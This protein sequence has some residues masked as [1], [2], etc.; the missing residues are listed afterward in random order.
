MVGFISIYLTLH[1]CVLL[2]FKGISS[3][4]GLF[5]IWC[6]KTLI[7]SH[8]SSDNIN[9]PNCHLN[10]YFYFLA[11]LQVLGTITFIIVDAKFSIAKG[12]QQTVAAA[13]T[14]ADVNEIT[15]TLRTANRTN[16]GFQTANA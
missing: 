5:T 8:D 13:P 15:N 9:C 1:F 3:L 12:K 7:Y 10:Y 16:G 2:H 4:L 11:L 14:N 6:F